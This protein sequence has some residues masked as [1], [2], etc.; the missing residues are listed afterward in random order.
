MP[1]DL[2]RNTTDS[3]SLIAALIRDPNPTKATLERLAR[4]YH[5]VKHVMTKIDNKDVLANYKD[6]TDRAADYLRKHSPS[7]LT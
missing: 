7:L 4:N 6:I 5:H 2:I 1:T 3:V